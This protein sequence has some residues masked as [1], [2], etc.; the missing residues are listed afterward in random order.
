MLYLFIQSEP[1][2]HGL[3][4]IGSH[5]Q[6]VIVLISNSVFLTLPIGLLNL[7]RVNFGGFWNE[8]KIQFI[9]NI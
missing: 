5:S 7:I 3:G 6:G 8:K 2:P 4:L 1:G 9:E